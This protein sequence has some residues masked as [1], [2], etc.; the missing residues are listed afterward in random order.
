MEERLPESNA[1]LVALNIVDNAIVD[2]FNS[3]GEAL[4]RLFEQMAAMSRD[5]SGDYRVAT[6]DWEKLI[7]SMDQSEIGPTIG[8]QEQAFGDTWAKRWML[9]VMAKTLHKQLEYRCLDHPAASKIQ[10]VIYAEDGS[11]ESWSLR[12]DL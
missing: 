8:R 2:D 5:I 10:R 11:L 1:D 12:R 7:E 6:A 4:A 9:C 3:P